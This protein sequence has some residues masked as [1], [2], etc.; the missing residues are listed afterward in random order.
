[1]VKGAEPLCNG[2]FILCVALSLRTGIVFIFP[3]LCVINPQIGDSIFSFYSDIPF[4][5]VDQ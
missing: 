3:M 1:M 5:N 2:D 4:I